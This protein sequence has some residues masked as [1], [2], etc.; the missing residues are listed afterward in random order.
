MRTI[1][2]RLTI[3]YTISFLLATA[4]FTW[5]TYRDL[6]LELR[7]KTFQR[8]FTFNPNWILHGSYSEEEVRGIMKQLVLSSL[9][10]SLPLVAVTIVIG[11]FL[12]RKSLSPIQEL[13]LQLQAITP[14][15]LERR[16]ALPDADEQL[17]DLVNHLNEMLS[18]L[19]DSFSEMSGYAAKVAHELRT[20]LTILRLK[21]E[22]AESRIE[23]GLSEELQSELHRLAHVVDQS[24]LIAKADQGRL[25]WQRSP[26]DLAALITDLVSDFRFLAAEQNRSLE[27]YA[28]E[29]CRLSTDR[30]YCRQILHSLVTNALIH[31]RGAIRIR[32]KGRGNQ[33]HLTILNEVRSDGATTEPTLGLG[34]RVVQALLHHQPGIQFRQHHGS[35][36][37]ACHLTFTDCEVRGAVLPLRFVS[38]GEVTI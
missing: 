16:V 10:Y 18:R 22:Q 38:V 20:P 1:R 32:L 35:R 6:D 9:T 15:T 11:Y 12:A 30:R 7:R 34:L 33:A 24:L 17:R 5:L 8:E 37:H 26:V 25:E 31:G 29:V 36:Y 28:P 19:Q 2:V 4:V 27:A 23:P 21:L 13:N 3:W 14:R